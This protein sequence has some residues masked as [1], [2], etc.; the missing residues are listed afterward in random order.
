MRAVVIHR[1]GGPEVLKLEEIPRPQPADGQVLIRVHAAAWSWLRPA[2]LVAI[3]VAKA[4]A[5]SA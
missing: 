5:N 1:T 3:A 4:V 2:G